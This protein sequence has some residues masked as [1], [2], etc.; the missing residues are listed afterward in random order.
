[1]SADKTAAGAVLLLAIVIASS[2]VAAG[3]PP[4]VPP[5]QAVAAGFMR[6]AFADEFNTA[7]TIDLHNTGEPGFKWYLGRP[8]G[9]PPSPADTISVADGVLSIASDR[10]NMGLL[11]TRQANLGWD[12]FAVRGGAYFE[13]SIAFDPNVKSA[14]PRGWPAFWTM[15]VGHLYGSGAQFIEID[16]FE[17][18]TQ[19]KGKGTYGAAIHDWIMVSAHGKRTHRQQTWNSTNWIARVPG[20]DWTKFNTVGGLVKPGEGIDFY[21]NNELKLTNPYSKF[22]WM[23]YADTQPLPVILGSDGW[24]MKVD[25]VRVWTR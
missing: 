19:W 23:A 2:G 4:P 7:K 14:Q 24:P 6:L 13:A 15:D 10:G 20:V 17:Y 18:D 16:F 22:P 12:G 8:F 1:M 25:W 3:T 5:P 21:F 11:S 9:Y